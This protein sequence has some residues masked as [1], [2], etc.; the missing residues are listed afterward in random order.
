MLKVINAVPIDN[1]MLELTFENKLN[2]VLDIK[3]YLT[4]NIEDFRNIKLV[5]GTII[6]HNGIELNEETL[7]NESVLYLPPK[8]LKA[9]INSEYKIDIYYEN[10]EL[11]RFDFAPLL[12]EKFYNRLNDYEIFK[13]YCICG[14]T[15]MWDDSLD[16]APEYL[17]E[18]SILI[19]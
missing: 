7:W 17:Y 12:S 9:D 19:S 2:K 16:I 11:R 6:L 10:G 14:N 4:E 18:G 3:P 13:K 8:I 5:D 1:Y 15:L